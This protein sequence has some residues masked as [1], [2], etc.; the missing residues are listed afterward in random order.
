MSSC[1]E[2]NFIRD[3]AHNFFILSLVF[4]N[5]MIDRK[6][7]ILFGPPC[8]VYTVSLTQE[9]DKAFSSLPPSGK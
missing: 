5:V 7:C 9:N 4:L 8:I 2:K 3:N 1:W 6:C